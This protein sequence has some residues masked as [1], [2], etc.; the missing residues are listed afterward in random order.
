MVCRIRAEGGCVKIWGTVWNSLKGGVTEKRG[1]G[2]KILKWGQT[3]S[4]GGCFKKW[5]LE[6]LYSYDRLLHHH[7]LYQ[8]GDYSGPKFNYLCCLIYHECYQPMN[9]EMVLIYRILL[10][11]ETKKNSASDKM[12]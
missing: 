8:R 3:R 5:E 9:Q 4:R 2:T 1:G 7:A 6:S 11:F 10:L 12:R